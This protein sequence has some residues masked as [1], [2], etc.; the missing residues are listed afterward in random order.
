MSDDPS[1]LMLT[2]AVVDKLIEILFATLTVAVA[3]FEK[4][5]INTTDSLCEF[6]I[7]DKARLSFDTT[8]STLPFFRLNE[9]VFKLTNF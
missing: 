6:L 7:I 4:F 5:I 1:E 9:F 2:V 8:A 3:V